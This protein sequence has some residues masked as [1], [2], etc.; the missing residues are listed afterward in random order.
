M[1]ILHT[2]KKKNVTDQFKAHY[3]NFRDVATHAKKSVF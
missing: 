1:L 3:L 2:T